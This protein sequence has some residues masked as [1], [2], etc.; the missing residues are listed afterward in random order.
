MSELFDEDPRRVS[1][2]RVLSSA[3]RLHTYVGHYCGATEDVANNEAAA[4]AGMAL[5]EAA[6]VDLLGDLNQLMDALGKER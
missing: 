4:K 5:C 2:A 6:L 1:A 3:A